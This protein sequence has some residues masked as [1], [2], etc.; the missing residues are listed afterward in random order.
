LREIT[1]KNGK[2]LQQASVEQDHE[3]LLQLFAGF[4]ELLEAKRTSVCSQ[5]L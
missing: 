1:K 3:K 5:A 4:N 2:S